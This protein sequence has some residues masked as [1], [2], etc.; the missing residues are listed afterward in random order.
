MDFNLAVD[1]FSSRRGRFVL[2]S[3]VGVAV[4]MVIFWKIGPHSFI[5]GG[6]HTVGGTFQ[7]ATMYNFMNKNA[8]NYLKNRVFFYYP[9]MIYRLISVVLPPPTLVCLILTIC[10]LQHVYP[11]RLC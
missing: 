5:P 11:F 6:G 4:G 7:Y 10:T 1:M 9:L 3:V 2:L 8:D